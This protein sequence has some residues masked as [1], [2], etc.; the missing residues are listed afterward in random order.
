MLDAH[1]EVKCA[2][3]MHCMQAA[4]SS[5]VAE[6]RIQKN[7]PLASAFAKRI[8]CIGDMNLTDIKLLPK[9]VF[10]ADGLST[11]EAFC[12]SSGEAVFL[13]GCS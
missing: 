6:K 4:N 9:D 2:V 7:Q 5:A 3:P 1:Q 13:A 8:C 11:V 12:P 10:S